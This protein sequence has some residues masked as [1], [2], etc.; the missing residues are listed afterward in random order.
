M[1]ASVIGKGGQ[2]RLTGWADADVANRFL[3]H[4]AGR[5]FA[6]ATVRAYAYDVLSFAR[7]RWTC[8]TGWAGSATGTGEPVDATD[9]LYRSK[10]KLGWD[11]SAEID[12]GQSALWLSPSS[13][14]PERLYDFRGRFVV[15]PVLEYDF[16]ENH[17][18]RLTGQVVAWVR[19][20][21]QQYQANADDVFRSGV[22]KTAECQAPPVQ[23]RRCTARASAS[24]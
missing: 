23:S 12:V 13:A 2:C 9:G 17:F 24:P 20:E 5:A 10:M 18:F 16:D 7:Y 1:A 22:A 14:K 6:A 3:D 8:S 15:G 21:K 4:L 11:G 19:E